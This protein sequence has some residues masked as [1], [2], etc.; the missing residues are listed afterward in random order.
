MGFRIFRASTALPLVLLLLALLFIALTATSMITTETSTTQEDL[1]QYVDDAVNELTS[2]LKV[3]QVYGLYSQQAPYHLTKIVI[4][5]TP[6]FHQEIDI[7]TWIVQMKTDAN[8][9]PYTFDNTVSSLNSTGVFSHI[10]W[11]NLSLNKFGVL[12]V[13]DKDHSLLEYH[14]FSEPNDLAF[15]TLNIE[16]LSISKGDY[17]TISLSPGTGIVKTISFNAPLPTQQVVTLW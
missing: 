7:S 3:Q 10:Q 13:Q 17:V 4:Q 14:S 16:N 6:L 11:N 15:L 8:L 5:V 9:L 2:Y 12:V 1:Q